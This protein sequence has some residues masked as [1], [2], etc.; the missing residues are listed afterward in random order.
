[1]G[2]RLRLA[3]AKRGR[4]EGLCLKFRDVGQRNA[5]ARSHS[6]IFW[7]SDPPLI[8]VETRS[9]LNLDYAF[10]RRRRFGHEHQPDLA[11]RAPND[12][13]TAT[14]FAVLCHIEID[15]IRNF[16]VRV[17]DDLSTPCRNISNTTLDQ[18]A[19]R[20]CSRRS[21]DIEAPVGCNF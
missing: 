3:R 1:M 2:T 17:A 11:I 15:S 20:T 18:L 5:L 9:R 6:F 8:F 7:P 13:A 12:L 19:R 4:A 14:H 16:G 21:F 10:A